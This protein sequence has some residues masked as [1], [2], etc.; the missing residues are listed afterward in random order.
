MRLEQLMNRDVESVAPELPAE[1]AW[2]R[3][4]TRGIRHLVVREGGKVV[5][6]VSERDLG[7]KA[8]TSVRR[9]ASV[10]DLMS[11]H[12]VCA[13][14][15]TTIRQAANLMR[16]RSV[17]CLPVAENGSVL[18]IVTVV[19]LLEAIGRAIVDRPGGRPH[20]DVPRRRKGTR[21]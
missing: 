12:V 2:G 20:R 4:K 18:G 5:G 15:G 1:E 21:T 6:I 16:G 19:D 10:S 7:G 8:G 9:G 14:P 3:M 17:G 13:K 11:P